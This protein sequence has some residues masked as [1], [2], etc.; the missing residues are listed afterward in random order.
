MKKAKQG[1]NLQSQNNHFDEAKYEFLNTL[2]W[3]KKI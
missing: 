3:K 1:I 2:F